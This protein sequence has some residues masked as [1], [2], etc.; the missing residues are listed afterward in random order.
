MVVNGH[1]NA[2]CPEC[3]LWMLGYGVEWHENVEVRVYSAAYLDVRAHNHGYKMR[4]SFLSLANGQNGIIERRTGRFMVRNFSV[5]KRKRDSL[6]CCGVPQGLGE[7]STQESGLSVSRR[8]KF[9]L[10]TIALRGCVIWTIDLRTAYHV[11][12]LTG[13][14]QQVKTRCA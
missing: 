12:R 3:Q 1:Q 7:L 14:P 2:D 6:A 5:V 4:H 11:L 8:K 10:S 9:S 13:K